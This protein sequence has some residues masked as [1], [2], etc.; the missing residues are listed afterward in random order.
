MTRAQA[1]AGTCAQHRRTAHAQAHST[2]QAQAAHATY[3]DGER[4][5]AVAQFHVR[6]ERVA[7]RDAQAVPAL[8]PAVN[9]HAA[10]VRRVLA[11]PHAPQRLVEVAA[12]GGGAKHH[13][14]VPREDGAG[15]AVRARSQHNSSL[16]SHTHTHA[17][18]PATRA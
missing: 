7:A 17:R 16:H 8:S 3:V 1:Q 15:S 12:D 11:P 4:R 14:V 9:D 13:H 10:A 5:A 6:E 18:K 2:A